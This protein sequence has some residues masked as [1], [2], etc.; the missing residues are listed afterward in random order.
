MTLLEAIDVRVSRRTYKPEPLTESDAWKIQAALDEYAQPRM[1]MALAEANLKASYG[2]F[3]G[4]RNSILL[5]ARDGDPTAKERLGYFGELVVLRAAAMGLGT[6]WMGMYDKSACPVA[7][8]ED[9]YLVL[10]INVGYVEAPRG[11]EKLLHGVVKRKTKSVE[12]LSVTDSAPP[13]WFVAGVRAAQKAPSAVNRQ[14]VTFA[15]Q[16]GAVTAAVKGYDGSYEA[17]DLG[18]A[19]AHF[20]LAAGG[21]W[22]WGN[23]GAFTKGAQG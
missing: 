18:I 12:Q 9:E 2:L 4:V 7:L 19:K 11:K 5:L 22:E 8:A 3:S 23:G 1:R 10:A 15:Y 6:C 20:A 13:D 16:N 14:P 17:I 21:T